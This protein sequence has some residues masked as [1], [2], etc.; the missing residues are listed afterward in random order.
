[1]AMG[2]PWPA[3]DVKRFKAALAEWVTEG[4]PLVQWCRENGVAKRAIYNWLKADPEFAAV[5]DQARDF[6]ADAVADEAMRIAEGPGREA[7]TMVAVNRD[8][9]RVDTRVKLLA[10]WHPKRYGDK[11]DLQ[12]G[13]K[14]EVTIVTGVPEPEP[15]AK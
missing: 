1:M 13:G 3:E 7:D 2:N 8:R 9:L 4:K 15:E 10:K 6:G 11:V 12:H 5:M 14:L